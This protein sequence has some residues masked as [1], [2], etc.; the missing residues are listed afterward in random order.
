MIK[1]TKTPEQ[2]A[3]HEAEKKAK[4]NHKSAIIKAQNIMKDI[5]IKK[6]LHTAEI[7]LQFAID[8]P[9]KLPVS[10]LLSKD[11]ILVAYQEGINKYKESLT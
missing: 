4:R 9:D 3:A 8:N 5:C 2:I 7:Q 11:E 10:L 1:K 6:S